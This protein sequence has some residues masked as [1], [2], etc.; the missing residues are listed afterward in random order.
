VGPIVPG[1][2]PKSLLDLNEFVVYRTEQVQ[3]RF[4]VQVRLLSLTGKPIQPRSL[5]DANPS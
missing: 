1:P 3:L 2:A 5:I 4:L